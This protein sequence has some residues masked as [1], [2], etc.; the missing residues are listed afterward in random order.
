[1][2]CDVNEYINYEFIYFG[3]VNPKL[4]VIINYLLSFELDLHMGEQVFEDI[5]NYLNLNQY[6]LF[7]KDY[8]TSF[9]RLMQ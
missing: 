4:Y 2:N 8:F 6:Y 5:S 7:I 3:L 9:Y 1:M